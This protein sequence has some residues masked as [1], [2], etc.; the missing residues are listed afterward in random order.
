MISLLA[1][2]RTAGLVLPQVIEP[3][4]VRRHNGVQKAHSCDRRHIADAVAELTSYLSIV[5]HMRSRRRSSEILSPAHA[6][7]FSPLD[8]LCR[9]HHVTSSGTISRFPHLLLLKR[10]VES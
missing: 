6:G 9:E 10:N 5:P 2:M 4:T 8:F 1:V 7:L 3:P